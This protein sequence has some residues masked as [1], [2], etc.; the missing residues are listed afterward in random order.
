MKYVLLFCKS[1]ADQEAFDA[2]PPAVLRE[3][4]EA[5]LR[6][7]VENQPRIG[8]TNRLPGPETATTFR[9]GPTGDAVVKD[10]LFLV[11]ST[12][13]D[14]WCSSLT[15]TARAGTVRSSRTRSP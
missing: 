6:W 15:R 5:V 11:A 1:P 7:M 10:G 9:F 14:S 13:A 4:N 3:R 2:L 8:S 12:A